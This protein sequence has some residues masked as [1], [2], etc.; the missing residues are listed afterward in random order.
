MHISQGNVVG[1]AGVEPATYGLKGPTSDRGSHRKTSPHV[2]MSL[3]TRT[4]GEPLVSDRNE[5]A[6]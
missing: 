2:C 3:L 6:P 4:T 1:R 5:V